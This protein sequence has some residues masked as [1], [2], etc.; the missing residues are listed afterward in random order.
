[1]CPVLRCWSIVPWGPFCQGW[2]AGRLGHRASMPGHGGHH[3]LLRW[4]AWHPCS[5]GVGITS[6]PELFNGPLTL[7]V[8]L[9]PFQSM[10]GGGSWGYLLLEEGTA[11]WTGP[12]GV[13]RSSGPPI[14]SVLPRR[15]PTVGEGRGASGGPR[16]RLCTI[17]GQPSSTILMTGGGDAGLRAPPPCN[18]GGLRTKRCHQGC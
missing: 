6:A 5:L 11:P 3:V 9:H 13:G 16:V 15:D 1:M 14:R 18:G 17:G 7:E 10:G 2:H 8:L 4:D 12:S